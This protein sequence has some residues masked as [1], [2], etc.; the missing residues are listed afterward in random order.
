MFVVAWTTTL[1]GINTPKLHVGNLEVGLYQFKLTVTD[2]IG[3]TD[4]A[5][6]SVDVLPGRCVL[7]VWSHL[8]LPTVLVCVC[9]S[10]LV[11]SNQ[12]PVVVFSE[13]NLTVMNPVTSAVLNGSSSYDEYR[14][15]SYWWTL[16]E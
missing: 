7:G 13:G 6:V 3:Q 15:D 11:E 4:T 9:V 2:T 14:I 8:N 16:D 10:V 12:P 5:T 1:Q